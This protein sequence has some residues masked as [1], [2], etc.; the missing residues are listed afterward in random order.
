[1]FFKRWAFERLPLYNDAAYDFRHVRREGIRFRGMRVQQGYTDALY[2]KI[3]L[4]TTNAEEYAFEGPALMDF[5]L[6]WRLSLGE[7]SGP[8]IS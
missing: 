6:S 4:K 3:C 8:G 1:M 7:S 5:G 2:F